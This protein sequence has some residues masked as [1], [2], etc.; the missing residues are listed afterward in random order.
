LCYNYTILRF[1]QERI[2]ETARL[3]GRAVVQKPDVG[4]YS[5]PAGDF[6]VDVAKSIAQGTVVMK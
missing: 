1:E 3:W 2:E 4:M 5:E 6:G